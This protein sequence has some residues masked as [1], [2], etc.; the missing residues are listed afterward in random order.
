VPANDPEAAL[1][2]HGPN[3]WPSEALLPGFRAA[4]TSYFDALTDLGHKLLRLL[5][6]ALKLPGRRM[7]AWTKAWQR[8]VVC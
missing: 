5:A 6:L 8:Q 2:L 4:V 1:P 7:R 3:Q